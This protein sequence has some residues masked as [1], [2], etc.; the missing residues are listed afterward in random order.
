MLLTVTM[1]PSVDISYTL[2][3]LVLNDVN[4]TNMVSKT[5]GGKGLNV[6]RVAR[7]AG[8]DVTTTG[9]LGGFL[10]GYIKKGLE[11]DTIEHNFFEINQESRNCIAIIHE[12]NQTEVLESGPTISEEESAQ[13]LK[14]FET[15]LEENQ[16]TLLTISGSL[17][18]GMSSEVYKQMIRLANQVDLPV[19][20]DA[21][22]ANLSDVLDDE[23]LKLKAI[24]PNMDELSTIEHKEVTQDMKVLQT[25]LEGNRYARCEWIVV[26]LGGDG[27]LI[28]HRDQYYRVTVPKI[29]V[30][31]PVGS[32]DATVAGFSMGILKE[33][34]NEEIMKTAMT[35]GVLNTL[36]RKTGYIDMNAFEEVYA[37]IVVEKL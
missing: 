29:K 35:T 27:S 31:S 28:K 36:N 17:P 3:E 30:V 1:N 11:A 33:L 21:S 2:D 10:G 37:Q 25:L 8:L 24:K 19:V 14:H 4:R 12:G 7:L 32:G 9:I 26:S 15:L 22:G 13:F 18:T 20:L 23:T 5:A 16:F 34:S 6:A